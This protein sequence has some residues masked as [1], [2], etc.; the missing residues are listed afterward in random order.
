ILIDAKTGVSGAGKGLSQATHFSE[1]ND[2]LKVY[3]VNE[4]QHTPEVEQ[5]IKSWNNN[6]G[7]VTF[8]THLVTMTRVIMT[9]IYATVKSPIT[10]DQ[11]LDLYK[12][13]YV[14]DY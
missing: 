10:V 4:H 11:L 8:T 3:K 7:P 12:L 14:N 1:T 6:V 9:T 13:S 2:N 5:A